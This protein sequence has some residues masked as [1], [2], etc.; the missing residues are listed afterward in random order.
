MLEEGGKNGGY[1]LP[2]GRFGEDSLHV[3]DGLAKRGTGERLW[4]VCEE[5]VKEC[6]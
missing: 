6:L 2:W 1:V 5:M 4:A 3:F